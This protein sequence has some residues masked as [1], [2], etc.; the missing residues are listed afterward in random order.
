MALQVEARNKGRV[1]VHNVAFGK[2]ANYDLMRRVSAEN[3]G[4]DR[5]I[6]ENLDAA[7]AVSATNDVSMFMLFLT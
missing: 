5:R 3:K 4:V 6:F 1:L 2:N 7:A